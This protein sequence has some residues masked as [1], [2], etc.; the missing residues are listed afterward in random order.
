MIFSSWWQAAW[1]SPPHARLLNLNY[2]ASCRLVFLVPVV[3]LKA[4]AEASKI[5]HYKVERLVAMMRG[6]LSDSIDG[7]KGGRSVRLSICLS[8]YLS[9]HLSSYLSFYL[10]LYLP[11]YLSIYLSICLVFLSICLFSYMFIFLSVYLSFYVSIYLSIYLSIYQSVFLSICFYP[12]IYH[13]PPASSKT[14]LFCETSSILEFTNF[15]NEAILWDFL[16]FR[17]WQY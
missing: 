4:A 10:S 8:S 2:P 9:F 17:S 3:P 1:F 5:G 14:K 12:S 6:W 16:N 7:P 15:K 13:C 11:F